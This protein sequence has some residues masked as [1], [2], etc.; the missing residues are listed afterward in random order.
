MEAAKQ[1]KLATIRGEKEYECRQNKKMCPN[2]LV[3]Q[4][5]AEWREKKKKCSNCGG[6][7][8]I[9]NTWDECQDE[10]LERMEVQDQRRLARLDEIKKQVE[11]HERHAGRVPK[12]KK[13]RYYDRLLSK[14]ASNL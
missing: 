13:K 1:R 11:H 10:F 3:P 8:R 9:P 14:K 6:R 12:S 4:S 7:F 2:C 5:Y